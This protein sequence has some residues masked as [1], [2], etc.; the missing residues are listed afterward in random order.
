MKQTLKSV[1]PA[2]IYQKIR[3]PLI[4]KRALSNHFYDA[5]N[6]ISNARLSYTPID[7]V[8]YNAILT[9]EYHKL[10]KALTLPNP[11]P[12]YGASITQN[13]VDIIKNHHSVACQCLDVTATAIKVLEDYIQ[14]I[15]RNSG[16]GSE[17]IRAKMEVAISEIKSLFPTIQELLP[18]ISAG[19]TFGKEPD[20]QNE[21][22]YHEFTEFIKNRKTVRNFSSAP[23]SRK[24]ILEAI[25]AARYTPSVCNRQPWK[26]YYLDSPE[27]IQNALRFQNGN[28]GFGNTSVG[29]LI[30]TSSPKHFPLSGERNQSWIDGGMFSMSLLLSLHSFGIG[31]CALNWGNDSHIDK[32]AKASIGLPD[33]VN[34]IMMIAIGYPQ[35]GYKV[36]AS[37][38]RDASNFL[39]Y[40]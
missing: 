4:L 2:G 7:A 19:A 40:L 22:Q 1:L 32:A 18:A 10:E 16:K 5:R 25:A 13:I 33:H 39:E 38:R 9:M 8:S 31:A 24:I 6:F 29:L 37:Q 23:I 30:I 35:E 21:Q 34:I 12:V 3:Y 27:K 28:N 36:C 20:S 17:E 14:I 11:R 15:S 26:A